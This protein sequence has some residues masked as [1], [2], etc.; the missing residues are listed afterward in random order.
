[1]KKNQNNEMDIIFLLDRSGSMSGI[2]DD[3]IGGYNTYLKSQ[4]N[5]NV[6]VTT[7]LFDDKYEV[8]NDRKP[9]K[10]VNNLTKKDYYVRGSTALLDAIGKSINYIDSKKS[11]KALFII[12]TDGYE[13]SSREY[14][15]E[16][17]RNMIKTHDNYEFMYIGADIDS[18]SEGTSLGISTK[19]ISNYKKDRKG[20][21]KLFRAMSCASNMY[22]EDCCVSDSWKEEL[23]D[24]IQENKI[25]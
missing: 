24:Y 25:S 10:K 21:S 1:M 15:K 11:K 2:E 9:I 16:K 7:I 20:V 13:N 14:D 12:T 23:E 5:N 4:K 22:Y 3:T 17:I 6:R 19:N 18:Y 8:L